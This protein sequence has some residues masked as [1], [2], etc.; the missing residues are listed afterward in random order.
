MADFRNTNRPTNPG[1]PDLERDDDG[2]RTPTLTLL[3]GGLPGRMYRI[4]RDGLHLGR[5]PECDIQLDEGGVSRRHARLGLLKGDAVEVL[6]LQSTNGTFVNGRRIQRARLRDGDKLQL[7]STVVLRFNYQD[8]LDEAFQRQQFESITRDTLTGAYNRL[9]F[10]EALAREL[11]FAQR[12][13]GDLAAGL[14]DLDHF[15]AVNDNFGHAAGDLVLQLVADAVQHAL[16]SYDVLARYGGEEFAVL[17]RGATEADAKV[18][19]ERLRRAVA[20]VAVPIG[21]A[22]VRPT[23]SIGMAMAGEAAS[24]ARRLLKLADQRLYAAKAAGRD[25]VDWGEAP[26]PGGADS[27]RPV[28]AQAARRAITHHRHMATH[29]EL[30][31]PSDDTP[32]HHEAPTDETP[33]VLRRREVDDPR[34]AETLESIDLP[35]FDAL[36][37]G[38][39]L[40]LD[41]PT[42]DDK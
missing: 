40:A 3:R 9:Y 42:D 38:Q 36:L 20:A 18:V 16:R 33:A 28:D 7:G 29:A 30:A 25:R 15:K 19:A 27:T 37:L 22:T 6:D 1:L 13:G 35:G 24:D 26:R 23:A 39:P 41:D 34:L 21:D 17:L 11:A 31:E 12:K 14:I 5:M 2:A 32:H 8:A 10:D 4:A